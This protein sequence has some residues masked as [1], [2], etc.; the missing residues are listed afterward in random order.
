MSPILELGAEYEIPVVED[1]AEALG[2]AHGNRRVGTLGR[3]GFYS[4]NGNKIITTS[5]GGAL[6]CENPEDARRARKLAA[7]AREDTPHFEHREVGYNYRL[8]NVLAGIGR[9]QL[10]VLDERVRRRR[11]IHAAYRSSLGDLP[12]VEFMPEA[13]WGLHTRW[14]TT[15]TIRPDAFGAD[16][17]SVR[18]RLEREGI[19]SR[20]L[21]KP[22]HLQP[23]YRDCECAGGS[24][25]ADLF[26]H[27]L[28]LP[29]GTGLTR[30]DVERVVDAV[31]RAC[32][33]V[34]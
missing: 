20:P 13:P 17:A 18:R 4:F 22:M 32:P 12:G 29:S 16:R 2:A 21:W 19:E 31:R 26:Q 3:F 8:S 14:L 25:S 1:A 10:Q 11:E 24:V 30:D 15:L 9:G 23:L 33:A 7:Q 6:V 27:G 28:C 34:G 5:G